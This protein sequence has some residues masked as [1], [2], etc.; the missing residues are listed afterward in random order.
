MIRF[1]SVT[2]CLLLACLTAGCSQGEEN[3]VDM[4]DQPTVD[5]SS[6]VKLPSPPE[7]KPQ[8][9]PDFGAILDVKK[10]KATFFEFM[11]ERIKK[12]NDFV[13]AERQFV[14]QF[15]DKHGR[16]E[17]S[18]EETADFL[19]LAD[20]YSLPAPDVIDDAYFEKL[21][22]R[23]DVVPAS[24][25]LAQGANESAWGTS[26]FAREGRN[27]FGIWCYREGCGLKPKSRD[28]GLKHEVRKFR[29]V[30][31]GVTYYAHN[32]N[33]GSAYQRLRSIRAKFRKDGE[34]LSGVQLAAG[35]SKYSE[36]GDAYVDEIQRMIRGNN[37]AR[38][39]TQRSLT[40]K[41]DDSE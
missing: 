19:R 13:W 29:T 15:R 17:V 36:R 34:K 3:A 32:I 24:L 40:L 27:F 8:P 28:A 35:L 26:R 37:L 33:T 25:V 23:V 5:T 6:Q 38:Y 1:L 2:L 39:T 11:Q 14:F 16:S 4:A 21:L 20:R 18:A 30:Q 31:E 12:T 22:K 7:S 9:L 10:K 41:Q